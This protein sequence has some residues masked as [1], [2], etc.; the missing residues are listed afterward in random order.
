M[1]I[2]KTMTRTVAWRKASERTARLMYCGA[3]LGAVRREVMR[4][5][6]L[7]GFNTA[8]QLPLPA[9]E[10]GIFTIVKCN[11]GGTACNH[12]NVSV[13]CNEN[14]KGLSV[15]MRR[16]AYGSLLL[17]QHAGRAASSGEDHSSTRL[18]RDRNKKENDY[19]TETKTEKSGKKVF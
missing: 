10:G 6:S 11:K 9:N 16:P 12:V 15:F 4:R 18:S 13:P 7:S 2:Q 14:C 17:T 8:R 19:G 1:M 5:P 3:V